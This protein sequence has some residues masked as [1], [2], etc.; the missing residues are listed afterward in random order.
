M[1]LPRLKDGVEDGGGNVILPV[2]A[3]VCGTTVTE[4]FGLSAALLSWPGHVVGTG[5]EGKSGGNFS[6][7]VQMGEIPY[8]EGEMSSWNTLQEGGVIGRS[9]TQ[10]RIMIVTS[11][12]SPVS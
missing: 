6:T 10:P 7:T 9:E 3:A 12:S 8:R 2:N 11:S 5:G 1:G 4:T